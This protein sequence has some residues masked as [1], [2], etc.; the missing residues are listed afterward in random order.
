MIFLRNT[1]TARTAQF[2]DEL[3]HLGFSFAFKGGLSFKLS[4]LISPEVKAELD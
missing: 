1:G 4:D 3:K 2:L